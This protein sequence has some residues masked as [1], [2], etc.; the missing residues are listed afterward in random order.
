[1]Y[2]IIIH[3]AISIYIQYLVYLTNYIGFPHCIIIHTL[4]KIKNLIIAIVNVQFYSLLWFW[5]IS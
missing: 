1:M 5:Y 2:I 3:L 4:R